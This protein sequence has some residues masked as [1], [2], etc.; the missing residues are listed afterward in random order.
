MKNL[1]KTT[2]LAAAFIFTLG[3]TAIQPVQAAEKGIKISKK[4]FPDAAFRKGVKTNFGLN[5]DGYL[6]RQERTMVTEVTDSLIM[7][8]KRKGGWKKYHSLKGIEYFPCLKKLEMNNINIGNPNISKNKLLQSVRLYNTFTTYVNVN[9]NVRLK[10]LYIS[11]EV[12]MVGKRSL[13]NMDVSHNKQLEEL[14]LIRGISAIDVSNLSKLRMLIIGEGKLKTLDVSHNPELQILSC[15]G[16]QLTELDVSA[17][18]KLSSFTCEKNQLK[19]VKL[20]ENLTLVNFE[21]HKNQLTELDMKN[22]K[23]TGEMKF[24]TQCSVVNYAGII[25]NDL[26]NK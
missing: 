23:V 15:G 16:N 13:K 1:I 7:C 19:A 22:G 18:T 20:P 10:R 21:C 6:S 3:A 11:S 4:N 17:C 14:T 25:H 8:T 12:S 9:E 24:D 2:V 26:M 5:K